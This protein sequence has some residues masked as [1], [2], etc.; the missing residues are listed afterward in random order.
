MPRDAQAA[1][2]R[3]VFLNP[4]GQLGGAELCLL[5]MIA[6]LREARPGWDIHLIITDSGPLAERASAL[7]AIV[8]VVLLPREIAELGDSGGKS[9]LA[10]ILRVLR[11]V[12]SVRAYRDQLRAAMS[13]VQPHFIHTNGFKMHVL[14][15]MAKPAPGALIWHIHDYVSSRPMMARLLRRYAR[16]THAII[17]NSTSVA[18]DVRLSLGSKLKIIPILNVV[19]LDEFSPEGKTLDLDSLSGMSSAAVGVVR[20]GLLATMAWWKGHRLFIDALARL[21]ADTPVRGYIIGG[22]LYQTGSQQESVETL[23]QYATRVG[24]A[25]R[26]GF[27]GFVSEPATAMRALDVVV[28]TSTEPEPF[29]RVIVEAM[30]C[31]KPVISSGVGGAAEILMMGDFALAFRLNDAASLSNAIAKLAADPKLRSLLGRN[32]LNTARERFGRER[33]ARELLPVYE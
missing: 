26:I 23:R 30:A 1:R 32:G 29:G 25:D 5:D 16:R 24:V 4:S 7:G 17:T 14:G 18:E 13:N 3:I 20:V 12:P 10:L 27:T 28:H 15:A 9:K 6:V 21:P 22:A 2:M 19:D 8:E 33:L 11:T 31:G